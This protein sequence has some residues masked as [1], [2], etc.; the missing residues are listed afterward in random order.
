[1]GLLSIKTKTK[2]AR[3]FMKLTD[4]EFM[5]AID[6]PSVTGKLVTWQ[7]TKGPVQQLLYGFDTSEVRPLI[8][9]I[10]GSGF[11][12]GS[13]AMD[14]AFMQQFVDEC[15]C[16]VASIDYA[17][18]PEEM[19]PTALEQCY[20]TVLYAQQH[21]AEL[22]I[23]PERIALMGHSAGGNFCIGVGILN[24]RRKQLSIKGFVLDYPP[25]DV[26][27][28][29][30]DKPLPKGCIPP[31]MARIFDAAYRKPE[32]SKN[33]LISPVFA[34]ASELAGFPRTLVITCEK[35]S[36]AGEAQTFAAHLKDAGVDVQ[37]RHFEGVPHAFT[38]KLADPALHDSAQ[39]AWDLMKGF[40]NEVLA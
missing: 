3:K 25:C 11:T 20:A 34:E 31:Q 33:P 10:H 12:L 21:A 27:T 32:D 36:L 16:K 2:L 17:L 6:D 40:M 26:A 13:A 19:F 9:D 37:T 5:K 14:D 38:H 35:D 22:G 39:E 4:P 30:F 15:H 24:A 28:D 18:A 8:I 29:A 7:T 1:M 23:D